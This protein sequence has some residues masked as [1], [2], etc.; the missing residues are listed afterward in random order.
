MFE[1]LPLATAVG[2]PQDTAIS[3]AVVAPLRRGEAVMV[4]TIWMPGRR[5]EPSTDRRAFHRCGLQD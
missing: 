2:Q 1:D 3:T 5:R 4:P